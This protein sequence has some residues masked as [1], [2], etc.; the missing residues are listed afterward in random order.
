MQYYLWKTIRRLSKLYKLCPL[1]F[2][3]SLSVF[4]ITI[5]VLGMFFVGINIICLI[6]VCLG[7]YLLVLTI[8]NTINKIK[9]HKK[10]Q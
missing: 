4:F 9:E 3:Y 1:L 5:G 10:K 2:D 6:A 7:L 8:L